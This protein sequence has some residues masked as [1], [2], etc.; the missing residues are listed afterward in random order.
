M[1]TPSRLRARTTLW[2]TLLCATGVGVVATPSAAHAQSRPI[3]LATASLEDLMNIEITSAGRKEERAEDVS[4]AVYVI[5]RDDIRRS[6]M[7]SV[8]EVLRLV[9]GVQ[10]AQ[11]NANKWAVSVRGF[12]NLSST[13]LLVLVDGRSIYNPLFGSVLWDTEDLMLEDIERIEVIRGAGGAVWG[14]NAVNGVINIITLPATQTTGLVARAGVGTFERNNAAVRFGGPAGGGAYR[15][16]AQLT[17]HGSSVLSPQV[18]ADDR[19]RSVTGGFRGDWASRV[20]AFMLQ[21]SADAGRI[22]AAP[23]PRCSCSRLS[24]SPT[25]T[26]RSASITAR[27]RTW[28]RSTTPRSAGGTISWPAAATA[29]SPKRWTAAPAIRSSRAARTS[30]C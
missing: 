20:D 8:P 30:T 10:V 12:N 7:T 1:R 29:T 16:Y 4:A 9:P 11:I 5:T 21:G 14:A 15:A 23:A 17:N 28:T 2:V 3:D 19:W 22:R 25:A 18:S 13:K 27:R 26:K 24:T 6:G